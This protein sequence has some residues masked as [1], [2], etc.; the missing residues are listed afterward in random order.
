MPALVL[1]N[2]SIPI[3]L[4]QPLT[5]AEDVGEELEIR[6]SPP[7]PIVPAALPPSLFHRSCGKEDPSFPSWHQVRT[8]SPPPGMAHSS[9]PPG[10]QGPAEVKADLGP[11]GRPGVRG[12]VTSQ[13]RRSKE[14]EFM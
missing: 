10:F 1:S 8:A 12:L 13:G 3:L 6:A 14:A 2:P 9:Q 7:L 5:A 11:G 4:L